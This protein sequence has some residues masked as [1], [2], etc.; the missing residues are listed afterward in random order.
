MMHFI[1][2]KNEHRQ[3]TGTFL[4]RPTYPVN[5]WEPCSE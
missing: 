2:H 5:R 1:V 4:V 3:P